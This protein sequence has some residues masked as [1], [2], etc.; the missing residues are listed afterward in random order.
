MMISDSS[1][2]PSEGSHSF[3]QLNEC[4]AD[5]TASPSRCRR[6]CFKPLFNAG[7]RDATLS[8]HS[9]LGM[10][11]PDDRR[12]SEDQVRQ[13]GFSRGFDA[14]QQDACSMIREEMAPQIKS[15]ADAFG[16]WNANMLR[17]EA[18]SN[19]H[20]LQ[21]AD[22]IVKKVLGALPEFSADKLDPLKTELRDNMRE[23]YRLEFK[24]NPEDLDVL[25]A[26]MA[27]EYPQWQRWD[28]ITMDGDPEVKRGAIRVKAGTRSILSKDGII[29]SLEALLS[30]VSTK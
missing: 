26:L 24:L 9:G 29:R 27:C 22:S 20:I 1:P 30:R 11:Q 8:P 23:A 21:L 15:V 12:D 28:Y 17:F 6:E 19:P 5:G 4:K 2:Q 25:C 14:G 13:Q 16:H 3:P 7:R 18:E 10:P